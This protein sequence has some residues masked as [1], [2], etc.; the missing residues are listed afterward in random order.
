MK[1][2]GMQETYQVEFISPEYKQEILLKQRRWSSYA[3]VYLFFQNP[4]Q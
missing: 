4:H 1:L 2:L 3:K